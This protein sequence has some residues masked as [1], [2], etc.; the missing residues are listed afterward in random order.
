VSAVDP[1]RHALTARDDAEL[2]DPYDGGVGKLLRRMVEEEDELLAEWDQSDPA[3]VE[4]AERE[5]RRWLER[6]YVAVRSDDG[7]HFEPVTGDRLP[8]DAAEVI[9]TVAMGGG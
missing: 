2:V 9:L 5:Y 3:S 6:R 7:A 8:V 4:T 1:P